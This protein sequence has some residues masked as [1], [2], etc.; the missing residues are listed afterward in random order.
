MALWKKIDG[1]HQW[2]EVPKPVVVPQ[3]NGLEIEAEKATKRAKDYAEFTEIIPPV[4][5]NEATELKL[6]ESIVEVTVTP[7]KRLPKKKV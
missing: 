3:K 6:E 7:K 1:V 4:V 5:S 2:V